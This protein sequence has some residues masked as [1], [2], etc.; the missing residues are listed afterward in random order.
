VATRINGID[1]KIAIIQ[2]ACERRF[3]IRD[4]YIH[5]WIW[6]TLAA[7]TEYRKYRDLVAH[8]RIIDPLESIGE[9]ALKRGD[10]QEILLSMKALNALYD[11]ISALTRELYALITW[12]EA[13]LEFYTLDDKDQPIPHLKMQQDMMRAAAMK[14]GVLGVLGVGPG[15][16]PNRQQM[17]QEA[18][19]AFSRYQLSRD[20]RRSLPP[21]PPFPKERR[22]RPMTEGAP[23][24]QRPHSGGQRG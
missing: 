8:S 15:T 14:E 20:I 3:G 7:A 22:E 18:Q 17:S 21:L 12:F 16:V 24:T 10:V 23:K 2:T 19:F 11:H 4:G 9:M 1:G 13:F 6:D 5:E